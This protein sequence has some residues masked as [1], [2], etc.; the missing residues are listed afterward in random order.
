MG[1][2]YLPALYETLCWQASDLHPRAAPSSKSSSDKR[3]SYHWVGEPLALLATKNAPGNLRNC[4]K[5]LNFC[6]FKYDLPL[7]AGDSHLDCTG[8]GKEGNVKK[9]NK[10]L[11]KQGIQQGKAKVLV[12]EY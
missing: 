12:E 3:C 8:L 10:S 7:R 11:I 2:S 4:I 1:A 6:S 5:F 9:T